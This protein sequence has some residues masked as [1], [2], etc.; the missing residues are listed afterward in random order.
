MKQM[1]DIGCQHFH[2]LLS[3]SFFQ[4][5]SNGKS[6]CVMHDLTNDLARYVSKEICFQLGNKLEDAKSCAKTRHS[7][8][9]RHQYEI[10]Q[11]FEGCV[12]MMG[13]RTFLAL[14]SMA[15]GRSYLTG[16]V[17]Y[18]LVPKLKR[19]R[20]LSLAG[21]EFVGLPSSI[22]VL[23]HLRYLNLSYTAIER[24]P[25]SIGEL[26]NLQIL[27][28]RGC[29]ELIELPFE[30]GT[31]VN[32]QCFDISGT[33][34]LK[35]MPVQIGNLTRLRTLTKFI[36]GKGKGLKLTELKKFS[37]LQ[38]K[39][40][41][42]GL[43]N[44]VDIR[45]A[46]FASLKEK[47]G[48]EVLE[49]TWTNAS[50]CSR[51]PNHEVQVLDSLQP[52]ENLLKLSVKSFGGIEFSSWIGDP[53]FANMVWLNLCNCHNITSLPPLGRLP[54][55][56]EL[57]INGMNEVK[58]IGVEFYGNGSSFP[59]LETLKIEDMLEWEQWSWSH[60]LNREAAIKFPSLHDLTISNCP[61]SLLGHCLAVFHLF[62]NSI[63]KNVR[64]QFSEMWVI[65]PL[66]LP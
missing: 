50:F 22:G 43:Q 9:I 16:K 62:E 34:K 2:D 61:K 7:S 3:R 30:I 45:G 26:F 46:D 11:K 59:S 49:L 4:W 24:L 27:R 37:Q 29:K 56:K 38:G 58:E 54:S 65:S 39:L 17:L 8:F 25:K 12:D 19:L 44:V 32:L 5:S 64:R 6:R 31:L 40:H 10:W 28:L 53:T 60:D 33:D 1:Q 20:L 51:N 14:P 41:I 55:L 48:P 63:L 13:L 18:D 52:L 47:Q 21:Y 35:E 15:K 66:L 42:T 57:R 36:V 23:K